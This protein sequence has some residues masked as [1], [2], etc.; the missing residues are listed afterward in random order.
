MLMNV[1]PMSCS[2]SWIKVLTG[3]GH[4][5]EHCGT[6]LETF[7]LMLTS[8]YQTESSNTGILSGANPQARV[9]QLVRGLFCTYHITYWNI[10]INRLDQW[11]QIGSTWPTLQMHHSPLLPEP[12][13]SC[14][15]SA[16][17]HTGSHLELTHTV[18][19][20]SCFW[21]WKP[22]DSEIFKCSWRHLQQISKPMMPF[23]ISELRSHLPVS[24]S[25]GQI[26]IKLFC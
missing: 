9:L 21:A 15:F 24:H 12:G 16:T 4:K 18:R 14:K 3:T 2:R 5:T 11:C 1:C 26:S 6:P 10:S 17:L 22:G 20:T 19:L 25:G 7:P 13:H 23:C 8:V